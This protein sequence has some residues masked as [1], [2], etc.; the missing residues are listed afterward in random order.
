MLCA[1]AIKQL[2]NKGINK[3]TCIQF[4]SDSPSFFSVQLSQNKDVSAGLVI[5]FDTIMENYGNNYIQSGGIY[6]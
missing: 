2:H 1:T 5:P 6:M 4:I 3:Y